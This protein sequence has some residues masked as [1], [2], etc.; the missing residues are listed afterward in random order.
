MLLHR[1]AHNIRLLSKIDLNCKLGG[2]QVVIKAQKGA[3]CCYGF[4]QCVQLKAPGKRI[5]REKSF[6]MQSA[7]P[8]KLASIRLQIV[9]K[10]YR[11]V[12]DIEVFWNKK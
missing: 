11:S 2:H 10:L 8:A 1:L 3:K 4:S 6:H 7:P 5:S 9:T 12:V